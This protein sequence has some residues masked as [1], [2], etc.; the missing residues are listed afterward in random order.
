MAYA[1]VWLSLIGILLLHM[2][3]EALPWQVS[4]SWRVIAQQVGFLLG[5]LALLAGYGVGWS[6]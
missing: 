1:G 5:V 6:M 2:T 4:L 3:R